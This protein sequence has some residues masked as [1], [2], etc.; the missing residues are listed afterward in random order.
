M[1]SATTRSPRATW[2]ASRPWS[3][4][5]ATPART[6]SRCS[7]DGRT[8]HRA[9]GRP[10]RRGRPHGGIAAVGL[11]ARD[12]LRLEAGMP[13][14][15]NELDRDTNPFEAGLGRVVKLDKPDDFVGRAALEQRGPR[16]PSRS[17]WSAWS[18]RDAA[19]PG[20]ATRSGRRAADRGRDQRHAIAD[21]RRADRDG[22]RRDRRQPSRVPCS[23]SGSATRVSPRRSCRC[24]STAGLAD[25][26]PGAGRGRR[27]R[28][29]AGN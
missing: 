4:G 9:V 8:R 24:R 19:S 6:A 17:A 14:Y 12:T 7:S 22:L 21:A 13:L 28:Q 11:G 10:A 26:S 5:P 3:P 2:P 15:G 18:S 20:T 29:A 27:G 16:W 1:R 25:A 23:T